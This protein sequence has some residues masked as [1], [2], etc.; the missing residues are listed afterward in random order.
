MNNYY[1]EF[2]LLM[3]YYHKVR[4]IVLDNADHLAEKKA[5]KVIYSTPSALLGLHTPT[6]LLNIGYSKSFKKGRKL[7][8]PTDRSDYLSYEYDKDGKLLRITDHGDIFFYCFW[9]EF[10]FEWA[11]PI[12]RY[13][14]HYYGYPSKAKVSMWD[15]QGRISVFAQI[16]NAAMWIEKYSYPTDTP[17]SAICEQWYYIPD[18]LHSS[19]DKSISETGSPAQLWIYRLDITNPKKITGKMIESF[20]RDKSVYRQD[21]QCRLAPQKHTKISD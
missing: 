5:E 18:L 3:D 15:E 1:Q 20:E 11:I 13:E 6:L 14:D 8:S 21:P 17:S 10:G 9:E 12:Y 4:K 19:K 2:D 16:D 7:N